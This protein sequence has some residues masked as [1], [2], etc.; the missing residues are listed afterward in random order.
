MATIGGGGL[1]TN[2]YATKAVT[3]TDGL[4]YQVPT[5]RYA[6]IIVHA[7]TGSFTPVAQQLND[8]GTII[9]RNNLALNTEYTLA[10]GTRLRISGG[11]AGAYT[12]DY[13]VI[14]FSNV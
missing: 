5:G 8:A 13:S 3:V 4:I 12:M 2:S 1:I 9:I 14:E 11:G 10:G 6:V 7:M